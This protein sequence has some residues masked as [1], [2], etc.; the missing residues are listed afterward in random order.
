MKKAFFSLALLCFAATGAFAQS[1]VCSSASPNVGQSASVTVPN[2][3]GG[4]KFLI[5]TS[6]FAVQGQSVAST[7]SGAPS[8]TYVQ[9]SQYSV[10]VT[11]SGVVWEIPSATSDLIGQ[12]I[13]VAW[14]SN[15]NE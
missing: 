9:D 12:T 11:G 8:Q 6:A 4:D 3:A 7:D 15:P 13:T 1:I 14:P 5:Y 2:F 10:A